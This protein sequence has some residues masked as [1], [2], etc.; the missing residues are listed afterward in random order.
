MTKLALGLCKRVKACVR[1]HI[2][3]YVARVLEA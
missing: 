2:P 1:R 3:A